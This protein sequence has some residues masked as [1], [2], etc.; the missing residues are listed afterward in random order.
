MTREEYMAFHES[1][2]ARMIET[3]RK[4]NADYT[5]GGA[6]P[7]S[8]FTAVETWHIPT[9]H[10]FITRMSDKFA[11]VSTFVKKGVLQVADETV[12]DSLLDLANYCILFAGY[13]RGKKAKATPTVTDLTSGE[14][15]VLTPPTKHYPPGVR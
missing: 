10:G 12:E 15:V 4:K 8:N 1:C 14:S 7:F 3:T 9:E 11:R 13:I 5:G 2:C 6:D